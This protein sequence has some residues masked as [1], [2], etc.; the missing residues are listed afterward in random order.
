[1]LKARRAV[2]KRKD[3]WRAERTNIFYFGCNFLNKGKQSRVSVVELLDTGVLPRGEVEFH[4]A[5]DAVSLL[6]LVYAPVEH[7]LVAGVDLL[8][9]S[10]HV[11]EHAVSNTDHEEACTADPAVLHHRHVEEALCAPARKQVQ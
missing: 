6:V 9:D 2:G 8:R 4:R 7:Q 1:M 11:F 5:Q 3:F 10:V